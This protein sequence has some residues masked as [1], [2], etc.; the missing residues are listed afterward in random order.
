MEIPGEVVRPEEVL[1]EV[2]LGW[3]NEGRAVIA[4]IAEMAATSEGSLLGEASGVAIP[5]DGSPPEVGP[6]ITCDQS[7]ELASDLWTSPDEGVGING[8]LSV[9]SLNAIVT[10]LCDPVMVTP[11]EAVRRTVD[12]CDQTAKTVVLMRSPGVRP[13][14]TPQI[15]LLMISSG[16]V[17][18][19]RQLWRPVA[20]FTGSGAPVRCAVHRVSCSSFETPKP[21]VFWWKR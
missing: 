21:R 3:M 4:V 2:R 19:P 5:S 14:P 11:G 13:S 10:C 12:R 7:V 18:P 20:P 16:A 15:P 6:V 1:A 8:A 17:M 9:A